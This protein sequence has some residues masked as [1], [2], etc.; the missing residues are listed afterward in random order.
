MSKLKLDPTTRAK[1]IE[2]VHDTVF[3]Q[4]RDILQLDD[5]WESFVSPD[6]EYDIN[7]W[8]DDASAEPRV[9]VHKMCVR[10]DGAIVNDP[11]FDATSLPVPP[12]AW[13]LWRNAR[14]YA[15]EKENDNGR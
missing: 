14:K 9:S 3:A 4:C 12:E 10:R 15:M 5:W 11:E 7:L 6:A 13:N 2:L 1:M 8:W